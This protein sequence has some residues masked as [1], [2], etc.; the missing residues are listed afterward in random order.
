MRARETK[1][2]Q[3]GITREQAKQAKIYCLN[4]SGERARNLRRAAKKANPEIADDLFISLRDGRSY[5]LQMAHRYIPI[6]RPDFYGYRRRCLAFFYKS[7]FPEEFA[8]EKGR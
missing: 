3:Y 6:S 5:D 8:D 1:Y 4:A 2:E 7:L